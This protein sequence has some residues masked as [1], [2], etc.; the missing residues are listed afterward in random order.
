[1]KKF[2][3]AH[4]RCNG[5]KEDESWTKEYLEPIQQFVDNT[6]NDTY[7]NIYDVG[8]NDDNTLLFLVEFYGDTKKECEALLTVFKSRLKELLKSYGLKQ[9]TVTFKAYGDKI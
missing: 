4:L 5:V 3:N 6:N 2:I 9:V 1:M 7:I 8:L